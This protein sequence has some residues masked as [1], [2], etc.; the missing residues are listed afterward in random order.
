MTAPE[1]PPE[2]AKLPD[3]S[4]LAEFD[5]EAAVG[6]KLDR[7]EVTLL[8]APERIV[9]VCEFLKITRQYLYLADITAVDWYPAEPRFEIVYHIYS[10]EHK[11]RLRLKARIGGENPA[12]ASVTSV[13]KAANWYEREVFDLFGVQ[14]IHHPNLK[15]ILMPEDWEGHPLRKDYPVTGYR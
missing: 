12:I 9:P 1:L 6:G 10:H 5:P 2:V 14:F 3:S 8:I 4:A 15:R 11:Q 13:W 7:G